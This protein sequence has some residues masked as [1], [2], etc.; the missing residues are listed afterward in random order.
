MGRRLLNDGA[1]A[2]VMPNV[3][4][5]RAGKEPDDAALNTPPQSNDLR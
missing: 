5:D 2:M 1:A 4:G 3:K